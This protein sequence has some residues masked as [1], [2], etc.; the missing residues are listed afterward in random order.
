[1]AGGGEQSG[2]IIE[3]RGISPPGQKT[4]TEAR[5]ITPGYFK[6]MGV[7]LL[8]GRD[9]TDHDSA[10]KPV[11]CIINETI[12]RSFFPGIDPLGK[13]VRLGD[14]TPDEA[15]NPFYSIVGI[16]RDVRGWA[17]ETKPIPEVY[18]PLEQEYRKDMTFVVRADVVSASSLERAIR[19]EMKSLDPA[20]PVANYRTME[21]LVA[22]AV[23]R[24]RFSAFLFG[25]F[26]ASAL[27]LTV[28][29]LY[30]VVAYAASQRTREIGV[31]IALG[32]SQRN[33]L[34]LVIRQGMLP[35]L[36]GLI[37]GIA[38]AFALTRLLAAQLYEVSPADPATF[39]FVIAVLLLATF[40]A[41][42]LPACR[43]TKI[44]PMMALRYE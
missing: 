44:D 6:T 32:A 4:P 37:I 1:L 36:A 9:F 25:L 11:V 40:A 43:A 39:G 33:I 24:P 29:G 21:R 12:A 38:G 19:S 15:N 42:W 13:R 10:D 35:A 3:G 7:T 22:N 8:R 28:V 18:L 17:L 2:L 23:A 14:G 20:L 31:R 30:G 5:A 16:A 41:C 34:A 26:A 27:L